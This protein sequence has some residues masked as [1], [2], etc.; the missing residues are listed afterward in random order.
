MRF[1]SQVIDLFNFFWQ[2]PEMDQ[3]L[4]NRAMQRVRKMRHKY[5]LMYRASISN[6]DRTEVITFN[7]PLPEFHD[8]KAESINKYLPSWQ[9]DESVSTINKMMHVKM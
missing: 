2:L 1:S 4:D 6:Q 3:L 8:P 7:N 9:D 5:D